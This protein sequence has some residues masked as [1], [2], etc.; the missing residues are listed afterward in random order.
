VDV[1]WLSLSDLAERDRA[2]LWTAGL[3]TLAPFAAE[4]LTWNRQPS[5]PPKG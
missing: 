5:P 4:L 3:L 1:A 2:Y